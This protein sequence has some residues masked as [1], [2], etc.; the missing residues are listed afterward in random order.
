VAGVLVLT[1]AALAGWRFTLP[2]TGSLSAVPEGSRRWYEQG[3]DA[4]HE[5][6]YTK[7]R[8]A[9]EQAISQHDAFPLAH[10]RLAEAFSELDESG[11]AKTALLKVRDL[12]PDPSAL[13]APD[14]LRLA[15]INATVV[16]DFATAAASYQE[17][18]KLLPDDSQVQVDLG[19]ALE[20]LEQWEGAS[21]AYRRAISLEAD[22]AVAHLR[23]AV[24]LGDRGDEATAQQEFER[25]RSVYQA[26]SNTEGVVEVL[27]ARGRWLN[28]RER[29]AASRQDLELAVRMS[30]DSQLEHQ[31]IRGMLQLSSLTASEGR[32]EEAESLAAQA[33]ERA[34][35]ADMDGL[36][37]S[38]LIDVGNVLFVKG[39]R[40]DAARLFAQA[41]SIAQRRGAKRTEARAAF[42]RGSVMVSS[43]QPQAALPYI[44]RSLAF[45]R[46]N[47]Y[48]AVER[49][50]LT[51]LASIYAGLGEFERSRVAYSEL[52]TSLR[53]AKDEAGIAIATERLAGVLMDMG[54]LPDAF[55]V[56]RE[57]V[58]LNRSAGNQAALVF[59]L[60]REAELL[61]RLGRLAEAQERVNAIRGELAAGR[62]A[63]VARAAS[64][65]LT[66]AR[67]ACARSDWRHASSSAASAIRIATADQ[68]SVHLGAAM[69]AALASANLG[70]R[71]AAID[72][73]QR[74]LKRV[75]E[76]K[77]ARV[78]LSIRDAAPSVF[79]RAGD[80]GAAH[81][82]ADAAL[83]IVE[84][85]PNIEAAWRLQALASVAA[86][87]V[88]APH[89]Q[90]HRLAAGKYIEA[91]Q[92]DWGP[93]VF[94]A[95][96]SRP[97]VRQLRKRLGL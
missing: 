77:D 56:L 27:L 22:S 40:S 48:P 73:A 13:P 61:A 60:A 41:E 37:A 70:R 38:S 36:A 81:E 67:V 31:R 96:S 46:E 54:R 15:A 23:L 92:K 44:E 18:A 82:A 75:E 94:A 21:S 63:Y 47:H 78:V 24:I 86:S 51:A 71:Q 17:L 30:T 10:A 76:V 62:E 6:A 52:L 4:I 9:L 49:R 72:Q 33:V 50:V 42:S 19:R 85:I 93:D 59:T 34:R 2:R 79:E 14:R 29:L 32:F 55:A 57:S 88:D 12:V 1:L 91:L 74:A 11:R 97:D 39:R 95:Y 3:A 84:K 25:A 26:A 66:Q 68:I 87:A 16:R 80:L 28:E 5:G 53:A 35:T 89:A 64:L 20:R 69:A 83:T 90:T 65:H 45:Y 58:D 43:G 7:A 8:R